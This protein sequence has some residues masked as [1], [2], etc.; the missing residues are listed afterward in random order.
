MLTGRL[1][2]SVRFG[3]AIYD[4]SPRQSV[5]TEPAIDHHHQE[6]S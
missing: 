1:T 4:M 2:R 6:K 3:T 5:V